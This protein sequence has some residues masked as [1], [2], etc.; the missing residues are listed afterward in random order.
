MLQRIVINEATSIFVHHLEAPNHI[1]VVEMQNAQM[2]KPKYT[3]KGM[4]Q[5]FFHNKYSV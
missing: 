1:R 3:Q 4:K 2:V 5:F